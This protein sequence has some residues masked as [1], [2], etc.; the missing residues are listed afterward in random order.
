MSLGLIPYFQAP[1]WKPDLPLLGPTPLGIFGPIVVIGVYPALLLR[2]IEPSVSDLLQ[3]MEVRSRAV[4]L[5]ASPP[6][7]FEFEEPR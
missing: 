2:R 4:E 5:S 6:P 3:Q 1:T 7:P